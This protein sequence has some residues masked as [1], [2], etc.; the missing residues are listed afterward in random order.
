MHEM[1]G[2]GDIKA[3]VSTYDRMIGLMKYGAIVVA[4][5]TALVIWL[6]AG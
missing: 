1:A 3:H 5:V 4:L 6:I 2:N